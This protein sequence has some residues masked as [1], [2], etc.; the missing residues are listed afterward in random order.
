V[1]M[2]GILNQD[3]GEGLP[4]DARPGLGTLGVNC[5]ERVEDLIPMLAAV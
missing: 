5:V 1:F 4:I 3:T 2:G